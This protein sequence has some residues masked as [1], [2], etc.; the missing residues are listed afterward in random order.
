[1]QSA[2][3]LLLYIVSALFIS[4]V[5]VSAIPIQLQKSFTGSTIA[6][7]TFVQDTLAE[8]YEEIVDQ[9]MEVVSDSMYASAPTTLMIE[10]RT[11][12]SLLMPSLENQLSQLRASLNSSIRPLLVNNLRVVVRGQDAMIDLNHRL[13]Y[14][15]GTLI[16]AEQTAS[17]IVR[18]SMVD[19]A[20]YTHCV[21]MDSATVINAILNSLFSTS[22]TSKDNTMSLTPPKANEAVNTRQWLRSWFHDI[23]GILAIEFDKRIHQG[24]KV[25][26]ENYLAEGNM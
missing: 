8:Y 20:S 9:V 7:S 13:A 2:R 17:T 11:S 1:M 18:E 19:S 16:R 14:Q 12:L 15:L 23:G 5:L 26:L 10:C 21:E 25:V 24:V 6:P 22:T 4:S 3:S